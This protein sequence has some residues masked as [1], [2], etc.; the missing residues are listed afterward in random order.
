MELE[1]HPPATFMAKV[2]KNFHFFGSPSIT[3]N[4]DR[5]SLKFWSIFKSFS[6][7]TSLYAAITQSFLCRNREIPA[8]V[9][10]F[11]IQMWCCN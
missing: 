11:Q 5:F 1:T 2:M 4:A 9:L 3:K 7:K 8:P 10:A 6:Y